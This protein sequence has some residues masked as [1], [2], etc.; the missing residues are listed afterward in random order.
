MK[1][2][3]QIKPIQKKQIQ[4]IKIAQKQLGIDDE[5]YRVML[6][7]RFRVDS[8]TKLSFF[9]AGAFIDVL[10]K[11]GFRPVYGQRAKGREQRA[12]VK[13]TKKTGFTGQARR[14]VP[15]KKGNVVGLVSRGE[16]DKIDV[17]AGLIAW[18]FDDG[19]SR[20]MQK[21]L[22][23]DKVRTAYD[24]WRTIEGLKKMFENKMKSRFGKSWWTLVYEDPGV[25]RY[26]E[27]H[28]AKGKERR[29]KI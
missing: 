28:G 11:R 4:L 13:Q 15:R 9:Q 8:C 22:K 23:I 12:P 21:R 3:K 25:M 17:L 26:I 24:A 20:W 19:L 6:M 18:K 27:E 5:T 16:L 10:K 2:K 1:A 7:K 29:G 14:G